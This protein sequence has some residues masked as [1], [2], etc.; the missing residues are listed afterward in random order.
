[1][2]EVSLIEQDFVKNPEIKV[3]VLL[4]QNNAEVISFKRFRVGE[5]IEIERNDFADVVI[6]QIEED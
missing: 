2:S 4:K 1:M 5:G 6:S 3:K